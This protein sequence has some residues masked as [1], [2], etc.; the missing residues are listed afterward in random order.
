MGVGFIRF[1]GISALLIIAVSI[2]F[3]VLVAASPAVGQ[4]KAVVAIFLL[5]IYALVIVTNLATKSLWNR[6]GRN[7]ANI[8]I[9]FMILMTIAFWF[10]NLLGGGMA[11][12]G[13]TGAAVGIVF[14]V[15][16]VLYLVAWIWFAIYC[17]V[18]GNS[19]GGVWKAA[20]I[21]Y[22]IGSLIGL[23]A[24]IAGAG[25]VYRLITTEL[26]NPGSAER[27]MASGSMAMAGIM[28]FIGGIAGL[29]LLAGWICHAIGLLLGAGKLERS[30]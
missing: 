8:P 26:A 22:V 11:P 1:G 13:Q 10:L 25:A 14:L 17:I 6:F 5:V 29:V 16:M 24:A 9:I 19:V 2:L 30:Q 23:I 7:G 3:F 18:A 28:A 21:L 12:A 15:T 4:N 27:T 20:G